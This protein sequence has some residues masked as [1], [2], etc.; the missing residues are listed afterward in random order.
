MTFLYRPDCK[1]CMMVK[2]WLDKYGVKYEERNMNLEPP[3][4]EEILEWSEKGRFSLKS[5]LRPRRLS[6]HL[7]LLTNQMLLAEAHTRAYIIS[8]AHEH[9][10][11]PIMVGED[12]VVMGT[13]NA[14]WRK[15]LKI[16]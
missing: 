16:K 15:A 2:A 12:F 8:A 5:F 10:I 7:T 9:I 1:E 11:C 14:Q 3:T 4:G 6:L 13:E